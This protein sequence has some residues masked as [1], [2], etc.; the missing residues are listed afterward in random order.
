MFLL[1]KHEIQQRDRRG[2]LAS[3]G[4]QLGELAAW[5]SK[6]WRGLTQKSSASPS[7]APQPS[8]QEYSG[9][10]WRRPVELLQQVRR[11]RAIL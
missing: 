6:L 2:K 1:Q 4:P 8:S 7:P 11:A 5:R 10:Y 3:W 9:I